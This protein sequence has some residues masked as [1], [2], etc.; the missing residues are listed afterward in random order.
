[1]INEFMRFA[2]AHGL[3]LRTIEEGKWVRVPTQDHPRKRNGAYKFLGAVGFVQ[4]HATMTE[5][6]VWK[7]SAEAKPFDHDAMQRRIEADRRKRVEDQMKAAKKA[8][9]IMHNTKQD[10]HPYLASKGFAEM[11]GNVWKKDDDT[12]LLVVPMRK[13]SNIVGCQL[14]NFDGGKRFLQGQMTND[15]TFQ[16]GDGNGVIVLCEGYATALSIRAAVAA[17]KLRATVIACFSAH[18]MKRV[19]E[20]YSSCVVVADND[21]SGT[22]QRVANEIGRPF[23]LPPDMGDDFN[24]YHQKTSLLKCGMAL[25]QLLVKGMQK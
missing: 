9:W 18:N 24:D 21:K 10:F 11:T 4:N 7:P 20:R 17:I 16:I 13:G 8:A 2:Q 12:F 23:F 1:M 14:I 19:A 6:A 25:R 5:P 22:G 15:A 3:S